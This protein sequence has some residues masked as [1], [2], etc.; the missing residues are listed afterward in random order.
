MEST[1]DR[2]SVISCINCTKRLTHDC[3]VYRGRRRIFDV[4]EYHQVTANKYCD[5]FVLARQV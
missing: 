1:I 3:P 4:T 2:Q 5:K